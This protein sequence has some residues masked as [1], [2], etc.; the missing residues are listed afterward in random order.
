[1]APRTYKKRAVKKSFKRKTIK[2]KSSQKSLISLIK[3]VALV[4]CE[5]KHTHVIQENL[6]LYHNTPKTIIHNVFYTTQSVQ[7]DGS[8]T[9][10]YAVRIGDQVIARG[11]SVK[12][13]IANKLDRPNVM[14]RINVFKYFSA[15]HPPTNDIY[16]SQ[17][18]SNYM[19]RDLN[20]EGYKVIKSIRLNVNQGASE[21]I[22]TA[23]D[24]FKGAEG[25]KFVQFYIP[26]KN[27]KFTYQNGISELR[28]NESMGVNIVCYDS[29]GTLTS[30]NIASVACSVKFYFKDP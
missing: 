11:V 28:N 13:W 7:D 20:T 24:T 2:A 25:H 14:Y 6:Q 23:T 21:R 5:T 3:K 17:G 9:A 29:Y 10:N 16:F 27:R 30:D 26:L 12:L 15:T 1:M 19:I 8:G 22:E 4:P 18:T